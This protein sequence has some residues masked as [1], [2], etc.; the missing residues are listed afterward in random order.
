MSEISVIEAGNILEG[1]ESILLD[2]SS[3]SKI[4]ESQIKRDESS[5]LTSLNTS[6][7]EP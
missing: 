2:P 4:I 6:M 5:N 3:E 1:S 7:D